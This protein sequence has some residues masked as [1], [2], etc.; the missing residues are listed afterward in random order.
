MK[1]ERWSTIEELFHSAC[2]VPEG[3]RDC[4]LHQACQGDENLR[5]EVE[6]LLKHGTKPK[7]VL[8]QPAIA[9]IAAALAADEVWFDA[10]FLEGKTISHYRILERIGL[11]G[12][13]VVYKAEDLRLGRYVALKLL[14]HFLAGESEAL[15]RFEREA[16]SASA[17]NHQNIC[18]M[19]EIDESED[20]HL[21]AMELIEGETLKERIAR[22][23]LEIPALLDV[24]VEI[25]SALEA[26]HSV[27]IIHRDIKPSNILITAQGRTKLVDFGVAKRVGSGSESRADGFKPNTRSFDPHLTNTGAALGT[28]AYM[29]PEQAAGQEVD[30]R[31]DLFSLGV[32]LYEMATGKHPF[33]GTVTG[34]VLEAI[35]VQSPTPIHQTNSTVPPELIRLRRGVFGFS[36]SRVD[37]G[38]RRA[39]PRGGQSDQ[40][41]SEWNGRGARAA[42]GSGAMRSEGIPVEGC[43]SNRCGGGSAGSGPWRGELPA[44]KVYAA[45]SDGGANRVEQ[46]GKETDGQNGS[47]TPAEKV[48]ETGSEGSDE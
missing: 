24:A 46:T 34:E 1:S 41:H 45:V 47:H 6:S 43:I 38:R 22:G 48:D 44:A 13:G 19:Y 23:P 37:F 40:D 15:Q 42:P 32:V 27:G 10:L 35:R 8:E 21:M 5:L 25:C 9:L 16:R 7:S 36:R 2:N 20:L 18:T 29:S 39:E 11:G 33:P 31:S 14:P 26:A 28:T 30:A 4:Y 12:M 17:L 3:Q